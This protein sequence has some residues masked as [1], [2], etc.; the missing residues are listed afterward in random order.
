MNECFEVI[1]RALIKKD[2]KI[3]LC[4]S[5]TRDYYFFPGGHV[6]LGEISSDALVREM[7]EERGSNIKNLKFIGLI[8]NIYKEKENTKYEINIVFDAEE[9]ND[10]IETITKEDHIEF[11]FMTIEE[12]KEADIR[13]VPLKE[14]IIE[15]IEKKEV[16]WKTIKED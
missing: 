2:D 12:V 6:E 16:F 7:R 15:Y 9:E 8:E 5:I 4:R 3:L 1:S 10:E 14:K 13:P 11:E